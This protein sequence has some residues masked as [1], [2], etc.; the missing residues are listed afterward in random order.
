MKRFKLSENEFM[1]LVNVKK[2]GI[3]QHQNCIKH[4]IFGNEGKN[5]YFATHI[6]KME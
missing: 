2:S 4:A 5:V 6:S 1:S 3:C